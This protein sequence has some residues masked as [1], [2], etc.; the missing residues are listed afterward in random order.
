MTATALR[1]N[2]THRI[3]RIMFNSAQA[4]RIIS[5][6]TDVEILDFLEI[7]ALVLPTLR[8]HCATCGQPIPNKD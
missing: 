1:R 3:M 8:Q 7:Y 5:G 6:A 4:D 2:V